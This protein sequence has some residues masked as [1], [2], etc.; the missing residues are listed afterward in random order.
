MKRIL[1][2]TFILL[3]GFCLQT[4]AQGNLLITPMR[5]VFEGNKQKAELNIANVGTEMATYSISFRQYIMDD[6]GKL[7]LIEKPDSMQMIAEPY[8]RIFPRHVTLA[9][10]E[11]QVVMLQFRRK[12]DMLPGEYR[13]H[14]WFRSEKNY[15]ALGK[16]G[17]P[18]IDSNQLSVTITPIFGITIPVIIRSGDVSV[19]AT[20]SN[21]KMEIRQDTIPYLN[22]TINR[23]GNI[24]IYGNITI[25]YI[26][27]HGKS[28]QIGVVKG[29]GVYTSI[30]KRAISIKL[31]KTPGLTLK[32]GKLK[33]LY[34]SSDE[35]KYIVYAE[36]DLELSE[37]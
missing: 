25:E 29:V 16:M 4:S 37:K 15:E 35:S 26:P 36:E 23:T 5:V 12:K 10:G 1:V 20:L 13:S 19:S 33:V 14:I 21:L 22:L 8:L 24:S 34:T 32:N 7:T 2:F 9:P 30:N 11:A 27:P 3:I 28:Y 31:T 6:Q 17:K 18:T